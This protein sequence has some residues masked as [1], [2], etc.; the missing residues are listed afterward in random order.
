MRDSG[1]DAVI[2]EYDAARQADVR[3]RTGAV[4]MLNRT[5]LTDL[6]P[7]DLLRGAGLLALSEIAPLRRFVM[8]QGLAGGSARQDQA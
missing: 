2:A 1:G 7:A 6:L 5:L 3:L 4:D 8:R